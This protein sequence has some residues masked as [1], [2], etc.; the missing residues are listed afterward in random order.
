LFAAAGAIVVTV[1]VFYKNFFDILA[2]STDKTL[3]GPELIKIISIIAGIHFF[4][5]VL[6][7]SGMFAFNFVESQTISKLRQNSFNYLMLHS[8]GFF[9]N[10]F[11]GS[12]VQKINRMARAFER[13]YDMVAF[14]IIPLV[15]IVVGSVVVTYTLAPLISLVILLWVLLFFSFNLFYSRKIQ[16]YRIASASAD[17]KTGAVL[18]DSIGNQASVINFTGYEFE[19][20]NFK[21]VTDDQARKMRKAWDMGEISTMLQMLL[22]FIVEFVVFYYAI[23]FWQNDSIT[24]GTF[25]LIQVYIIGVGH[26]LWGISRIIRTFYESIADSREMVEILLMPHEISDVE[27]AGELK[28]NGAVIELQNVS[29]KYG[30]ANKGV[31]GGVNMKINSGEK[32]ALVGPS[33]AGKT[34]ITRLIMR[35]HDVL[36]GS[37]F[38]DGQD[39]KNVTQES[40]RKNIGLVPQDP[41]L[42]SSFIDGEYSIRTS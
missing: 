22:L 13:F 10:N 32:V 37:I 14:Q 24:V 41:V 40:L 26:Q 30:S 39:I 25:V 20:K 27:N 15:I 31:L 11:T 33:G 18:A 8:H 38:I 1:P 12:F 36:G 4:Q 19:R 29:F 7:R 17:S 3:A 21:D 35:L 2:T 5:W 34:T 23:K 28:I 9:A 6:Y 42:F 16:K